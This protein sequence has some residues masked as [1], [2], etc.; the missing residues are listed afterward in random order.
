MTKVHSLSNVCVF[1]G[2]WP[3]VYRQHCQRPVRLPKAN[4]RTHMHWEAVC[5]QGN[6]R[7]GAPLSDVQRRYHRTLLSA[8]SLSPSLFI[9]LLPF[10]FL[11][12]LLLLLSTQGDSFFG[13]FCAPFELG[14]NCCCC[15]QCHRLLCV[16]VLC[17][18]GYH[19]QPVRSPVCVHST[20]LSL[21]FSLFYSLSLS[22]SLI[23]SPVCL[24]SH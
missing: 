14:G 1:D 3:V 21:Y 15:C 10:R 4:N 7:E 18:C 17:L 22:F 11:V 16:C 23:D 19:Q 6:E 5:V 2:R 20:L 24:S 9:F 12:L 13:I 8:P